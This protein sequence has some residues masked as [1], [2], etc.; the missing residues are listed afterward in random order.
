MMGTQ[1][2]RYR[3]YISE[4]SMSQLHLRN[5]WIVAFWSFAFPG[6]GS[7]IQDR[8]IKGIILIVWELL[9]NTNAKI[10]LSILYTL[11]GQ[12]D[13]AKKVIDPRWFLLYMALFV[14]GIWDGYR[15]TVDLN[16][17]YMLADQEDAPIMS[18]KMKIG[19]INF[20]DKR[21][22]WAAAAFSFLMPGLGHLYISRLIV[23]FFMVLWTIVT[24]YCSHCLP[25]IHYT[26]IGDFV[27]AKSVLDMQWLMYIPSIYGYVIYDSY[28]T[29]IEQNKLFEK[30]QS[31]LLRSNYQW[32]AYKMPSLGRE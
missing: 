26:F 17:Q 23:G 25:A 27:Q 15:G 5:P 12:F 10:N 22:P 6:C 30:E 14:F 4:F 11:I 13:M 31:K 32:S 20:F 3:A 19:D 28:V 18:F 8:K 21:N 24:V 1:P 7:L 9:V 2:R 16:K 29:A